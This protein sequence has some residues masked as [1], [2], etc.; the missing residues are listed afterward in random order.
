M[1]LINY[2]HRAPVGSATMKDASLVS[3][4][5]TMTSRTE[6]S[7]KSGL[8]RSEESNRGTR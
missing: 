1:A 2:R 5:V 6:S 8:L 4:G 7:L 3:I